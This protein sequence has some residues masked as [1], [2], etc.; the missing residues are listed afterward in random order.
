MYKICMRL[1][2]YSATVYVGSILF[3]LFSFHQWI[4]GPPM[5]SLFRQLLLNNVSQ[6]LAAK[7]TR[8]E[9]MGVSKNRGKTLQMDGL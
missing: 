4:D 7:E 8:F 6:G 9:S 3:T 5:I 2:A 1:H